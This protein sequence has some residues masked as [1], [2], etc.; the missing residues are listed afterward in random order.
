MIFEESIRQHLTHDDESYTLN[1]NP[2]TFRLTGISDEAVNAAT[3]VCDFINIL[4]GPKKP[5]PKTTLWHE[6]LA[7]WV[8]CTDVL[9]SVP[10][11]LW[12]WD[13][14]E[15]VSVGGHAVIGVYEG[16][17]GEF[18]I[19]GLNR[20]LRAEALVAARSMGCVRVWGVCEYGE[21]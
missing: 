12:C 15:P 17:Y 4:V 3:A 14:R 1:S 11:T 7:A 21:V 18:P 20:L 5:I 8:F 10:R 19:F 16:M 2:N 9:M 6:V 13:L